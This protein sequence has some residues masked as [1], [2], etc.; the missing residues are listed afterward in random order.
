MFKHGGNNIGEKYISRL[1]DVLRGTKRRAFLG[2][3]G[4]MHPRENFF[5]WCNLVRFGVYLGQILSLKNFKNYYFLY[6]IFINYH[7]FYINFK[8]DYF[9]VKI[10]VNY[11]CMYMLGGSGAHASSLRKF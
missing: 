3:F 8:N 2:G 10:H 9:Q 1:R 6:K 7:F 5:K 11:S 4:G